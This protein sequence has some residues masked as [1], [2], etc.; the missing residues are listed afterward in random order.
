MCLA[1][2]VVEASARSG[3][4]ITARLAAEQNREVF[5]FPGSEN[6]KASE[7]TVNLIQDG[8]NLVTEPEEIIEYYSSLLPE[9]KNVE[10]NP[11]FDDLTEEEK[12]LLGQLSS[13][14]VSLDKLIEDGWPRER[15]FSLLLQLEMRD[16]LI[17]LQGN[18][19][20]ATN[21]MKKR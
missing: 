14:P 6:A 17:R 20:Q 12:K 7:G 10:K 18:C 5:A 11:V 19:Y 2:L 3:S 21:A 16:Y 15:L 13:Q 8:A 9:K 4:L 1:T